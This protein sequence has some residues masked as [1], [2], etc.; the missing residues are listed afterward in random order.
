MRDE[1]DQ[2]WSDKSTLASR[3]DTLEDQVAVLTNDAY[4]RQQQI[5]DLVAS[6]STLQGRVRGTSG[7]PAMLTSTGDRP[8]NTGSGT[9]SLCSKKHWPIHG[10]PFADLAALPTK[11]LNLGS[12]HPVHLIV[13]WKS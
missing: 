2:L 12:V 1:L 11:P 5:S 4:G 10:E 3:V 13:A 6:N 7:H 9:W 8:V